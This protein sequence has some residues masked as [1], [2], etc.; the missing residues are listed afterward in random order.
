M[1]PGWSVSSLYLLPHHRAFTAQLTQMPAAFLHSPHP[2]TQIHTFS[3]LRLTRKQAKSI[4]QGYV[5]ITPSEVSRQEIESSVQDTIRN[6]VFCFFFFQM[7]ISPEDNQLGF[8]PPIFLICIG[9]FHPC[10]HVHYLCAVPNGARRRNCTHSA[11]SYRLLRATTWAL[12]IEPQ[13]SERVAS[14]LNH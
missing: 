7:S 11:W 6:L 12:R 9:V 13:F 8:F 1:A 3:S 5:G 14:V 10:M 2:V 4:T